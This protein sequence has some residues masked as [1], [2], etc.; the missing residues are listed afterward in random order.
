MSGSYG[1]GGD[2]G[3]I[4][5]ELLPDAD[6][7][8]RLSAEIAR[9]GPQ[10]AVAMRRM[11]F[12]P[13]PD[14]VGPECREFAEILR[15]LGQRTGRSLRGYAVLAYRDAG[16]LSKYFSGR[17][18][19][20]ADFVERLIADGDQVSGNQLAAEVREHVRQLHR[21][22]LRAVSPKSASVQALRDEIVSANKDLSK[23]STLVKTLAEG[24]DQARQRVRELEGENRQLEL[25]AATVAVA[26]AA[27]SER[28]V[29]DQE[30]LRAERDQLREQ[31]DHLSE[32]L[33]RAEQH[34]RLLQQRCS[35]L[36][37]RLEAAGET[38][39]EE[40][41]DTTEEAREQDDHEA[42]ALR[43]RE[44]QLRVASVAEA[45]AREA[46]RR[47]DAT[48]SELASIERRRAQ[49]EEAADEMRMRAAHTQQELHDLESRLAALQE[50]TDGTPLGRLRRRR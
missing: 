42:E 19:P 8:I 35:D 40:T 33:E 12:R 14:G 38:A 15:F 16:R 30:R 18:V 43:L 45:E 17:E 50:I 20:P 2:G 46:R 9:G 37:D 3:V 34:A 44:E 6:L 11:D 28:L 24:L 4:E 21:A 49:A 41:A 1:D 13:I 47:L 5:G 31:V 36:E 26:S 39:A 7:G 48:M 22:A 25:E 27:E 32:A 10:A 23:A 29:G